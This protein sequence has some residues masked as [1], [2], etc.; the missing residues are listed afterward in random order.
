[1]TYSAYDALV[2]TLVE[3]FDQEEGLIEFLM[4]WNRRIK[5]S[6]IFFDKMNAAGFQMHSYGKGIYSFTRESR[7]DL[8]L[9]D[10]FNGNQ[11]Y[12]HC[13]GSNI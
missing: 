1:M 6:S 12:D 8:F 10:L 9:K 3:L 4:A 5:E 2:Q 11:K 7:C 13:S